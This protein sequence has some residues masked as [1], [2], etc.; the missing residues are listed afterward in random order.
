MSYESYKNAP[1]TTSVELGDGTIV[2]YRKIPMTQRLGERDRGIV[3]DCLKAMRDV[4]VANGVDAS[5]NIRF[6]PDPY[7]RRGRCTARIKGSSWVAPELVDEV[8]F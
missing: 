1:L 5:V 3:A 6:D 4:F 2:E 7:N 8:E